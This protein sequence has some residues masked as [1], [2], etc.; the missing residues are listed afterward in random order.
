M[1]LLGTFVFGLSG[2]ML[3]VR[4]DLDLFGILVLSL[5]AATAGGALRDMLIGATPA[6]FL[7]DQRYFVA[8]LLAGVVVF[9]GHAQIEKLTR[10]VMVLDALGLGLFA[11]TGAQKA[12]A[13]DLGP[14]GAIWIGVLTA[15]GGGALRDVL[16]AEVPRVLCEEIYALAALLGALI[17]VLGH[18]A[19]WPAG[20]T[21]VCGAALA[22][23]WRIV[24][25]Y[26]GWQ[27]PRARK[28]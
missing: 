26:R 17:V 12:L 24:S 9:F 18:G 20:L 1:D 2:A 25:V 3:A 22:S 4:R 8:A 27:V 23:A 15:C 16:V 7:S 28:R 5:V 13:Y 19:G 21:A 6:A 11:V 14:M 10:P